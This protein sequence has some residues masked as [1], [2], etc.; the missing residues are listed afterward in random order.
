M[1]CIRTAVVVTAAL[2]FLRIVIGLHFFLEGSS[3][4]RDPSWSSAG[5]RKAAVG[6]LSSFLKADLPETGDWKNTVGQIQDADPA[7]VSNAAAGW[8][9]SLVEQWKELGVRR[10]R[11]LRA[12]GWTPPENWSNTSLKAIESADKKLA[13]MLDDAQEDLLSYCR[14]V[15][16]LQETEES[17]MARDIPFMRERVSTKQRELASQKAGWMAEAD[18]VGRELVST[19]N[20]PLSTENRRR[21]ESAVRPTRLWKADRFVSWSLTTIGACLVVGFLTKFNA[22]GGVFFLLSVVAS[23]PFWL[24]A[25]QST[26]EQWVEI[27]GLLVLASAPLG[28]WAGIDAFL[29]PILQKFCPLKT[30]CHSKE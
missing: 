7:K 25:A 3:H 10:E 30:C 27:A 12:S 20:E 9:A 15:I 22:M 1:S 6:P 11:A 16:R 18:A 13:E 23:Q 24:P 29:M 28:A 21:A 4:L 14:E 8:R 2:T 5:F 26:Y 19:W 17:A